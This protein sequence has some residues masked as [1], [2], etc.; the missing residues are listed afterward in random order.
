MTNIL[1]SWKGT[2]AEATELLAAVKNNCECEPSLEC[3]LHEAVRTDQQ[4]LDDLLYVRSRRRLYFREEMGLE[5]TACPIWEADDER[6]LA[7][8]LAGS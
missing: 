6:I 7:D 3:S 2:P 8:L 4:F 5:G 1:T